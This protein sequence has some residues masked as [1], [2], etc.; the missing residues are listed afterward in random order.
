MK[1]KVRQVI[2]KYC[3]ISVLFFFVLFIF[4]V[5]SSYI[6]ASS[7]D[8]NI[9]QQQEQLNKIEQRKKEIQKEVE[10]L[11][12]EKVDYQ[13]SLQKIQELLAT[14]EKELQNAKNTYENT[15]KE[16]TKLEEQLEIEQ[17]ILDLQL[18]IFKNRVKKYYKYNNISYLSV[19]IDSKDFSQFLNRC[20]YLEKVLE[21]DADI[22]KQVNE[23]VELVKKQRDSLYN[24]REITRMLEK[25]IVNEKENI[26]MS[27]D[28]KN[29][30]LTKIEEDR[31]KQLAVLE[32]LERSSAQIKEIIEIAYREKEKAQ[33]AQQVPQQSQRAE[34]AKKEP[35]LQPKKGIFQLPLKGTVISNY[36]Q[37][38]QPDLNA[39]VF[40]SGIDINASLGEPIRAVS[41]GTVIYIGNVK[42]YGDII[43]LDHGGN[44]VTLYAHLAKTLVKLN[45]QVS[46][47]EIIG[48][49]GTSGGVN[50]PRLHFEVRVEGKP[51]NPFDWL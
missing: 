9:E 1:T 11:K 49:V 26:A 45:E 36:G 30:Y 50:S 23:Q 2:K 37:Q 16:I 10:R 15:L 38:K 13:K 27:V 34:P 43:I 19:L 42:G 4:F 5:L 20:R 7:Q 28:A 40:N 12:Q 14:A 18:I 3:K 22:I 48:Q 31:K 25:E 35:T 32:E 41:H 51:V 21:N 6:I 33:Q 46:K 8:V 44:V 24:K 17:N 47:G 39:Y 29:K